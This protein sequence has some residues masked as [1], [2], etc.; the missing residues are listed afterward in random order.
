M[1]NDNI[2]ETSKKKCM[3]FKIIS[4]MIKLICRIIRRNLNTKEDLITILK[5]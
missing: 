2:I 1:S 4:L 3:S 5:Y